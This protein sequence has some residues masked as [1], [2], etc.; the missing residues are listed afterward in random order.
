M[1]ELYYINGA[2]HKKAIPPA[3]PLENIDLEQKLE[4]K[5]KD[6]NSIDNHNNIQEMIT[7]F[8]DKN[9]KSKKKNKKYKIL[10]TILKSF[11]TFVII[12][13]TSN[14]I[15]LSLTRIGLIAIP[16]S[17]VTACRLSI[18]NKV[19]YEVIIN[20]YNNYKKQFNKDQQTIESFDKIYRKGLQDNLI[21]KKE[22]ESLCIIFTDNLEVKLIFF[23]RKK[24]QNSI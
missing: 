11:D 15:T 3:A 7:Y 23:S 22:Y 9:H 5:M 12:A 17:I 21:D 10:T 14:S 18:G 24:N 4:R 16:I 1:Y 19:I 13:T 20:K 6:V 8:K 2:K